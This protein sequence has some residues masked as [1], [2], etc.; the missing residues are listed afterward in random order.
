MR[1]EQRPES[2]D[3]TAHLSDEEFAGYVTDSLT[4]RD[5]QGIE[6]HLQGCRACAARINGFFEAREKFMILHPPPIQGNPK[7][8][9]ITGA[10]ITAILKQQGLLTYPETRLAAAGADEQPEQSALEAS[11]REGSLRFVAVPSDE[12][13]SVDVTA[14]SD[15]QGKL[16]RLVLN[17]QRIG[18]AARLGPQKDTST[19]GVSLWVGRRELQVAAAAPGQEWMLGIEVVG[20]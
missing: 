10:D 16:V 5:E 9:T 15:M 7:P 20:E 11:T 14:S 4:E 12:G 8:V 17:G 13:L 1:P 6:S 3:V 19:V 2:R 18:E